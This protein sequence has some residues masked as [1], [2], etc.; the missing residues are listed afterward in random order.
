M[1]SL[2]EHLL[3]K[4]SNNDYIFEMAQMNTDTSGPLPREKY[5]LEIEPRDHVPPH[6]HVFYKDSNVE[7]YIE[8]GEFFRFKKDSKPLKDY[9]LNDLKKRIK[10]W[11]PLKN[12]KGKVNQFNCYELWTSWYGIKGFSNEFINKMK[13][14]NKK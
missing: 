6:F 12:K 13:S 1:K 14:L 3:N 8:S 4:S 10:K 2:K 11:L 5:D 7:F 9:D